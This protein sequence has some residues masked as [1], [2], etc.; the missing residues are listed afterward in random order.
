MGVQEMKQRGLFDEIDRLKEL[1]KL[2][3]PLVILTEKIDWE[4]FRPILKNIRIEN[5]DNIKN[6]GRKPFDEVM[7][8]RVI[9]LQSLYGL[10]DDQM[11]FQLKDRRSFE[12]FVSGSNTTYYMPD[13]KTIWLYK[14][15]FM[16]N[17]IARKAFRKFNQKLDQ[18]KLIAKT[19]QIVDASFVEVLKQRNNRD[20]NKHIKEN[21]THPEEWSDN[22]KRQK[23]IDA[24][25]TEKNGQKHYGYKNHV[26]VDK[27]RK[28]ILN[29]KVTSAEV[30]DS[31]PLFDIIGKARKDG[32][33]IW[34][35]SAYRSENI[36]NRLARK[37]FSSK[38]HE[39]GYRNK[40][41]TEKQKFAN[42]IKSKIRARGEHV[43]GAIHWFKGNFSR[44]IGI[45]RTDFR[46]GM[47][48]LTY[49]LKRYCLYV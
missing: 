4:I 46:V 31:Q 39:K 8:F 47:I 25:W 40:A 30:H 20:E 33:P 16:E 45:E 24:R 29:Y 13:A 48:N 28:L 27:K 38:I 49:N 43:F 18:A 37:G 22:K 14:E 10:S 23:D 32:E 7:M 26:S 42:T 9:I 5:P 3:D 44:C 36:E 35:D 15:R 1:T 34:G 2:G 19:G 21:G 12:R 11:E 41:L 17:G 6:A